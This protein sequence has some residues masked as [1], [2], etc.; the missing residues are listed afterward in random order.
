MSNETVIQ[1]RTIGPFEIEAIDRYLRENPTWGR[2]RLSQEICQAWAWESEAGVLKDMACRTMLLKL[3]ARGLIRLPPRQR[4]VGSNSNR[5]RK[6]PEIDVDPTPI[7]GRLKPHLPLAVSM[8]TGPG[9]ER[10]LFRG[11]VGQYHYLGLR[12][13][14]GENIM[15]MVRDNSGRPLSCLLFGS[16][17]WSTRSRDDEIG[18]SREERQARLQWITNNTRFLILPWVNVKNLASHVL[19]LITGRIREDW[20]GKYGHPISLLETFV[21]RDRFRGTCYQASNWRCVGCTTGRTRN[22]RGKKDCRSLKDIYIYPLTRHFRTE[23]CSG[24]V[25]KSIGSGKP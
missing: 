20:R 22:G 7:T 13:T 14:V 8:I 12:S 1:G 6:L 21:D 10:D 18:W 17:A 9:E 3:E 11:L 5:N 2:T 24:S 25:H 4:G 15:Y 23:L 16:A 19:S